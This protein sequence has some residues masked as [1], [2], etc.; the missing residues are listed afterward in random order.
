MLGELAAAW[1]AGILSL[2]EATRLLVCRLRAQRRMNGQGGM[3][4][5]AL[6]P[7][8]METYDEMQR[9]L[10]IAAYNGPR[11]VTI[12]GPDALLPEELREE[13]HIFQMGS[14]RSLQIHTRETRRRSQRGEGERPR[15][16]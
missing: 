1:A 10:V 11:S 12:A 7:R 16:T 8:A 4:A 5:V 13:H 9:G 2:E 6:D 3:M 14:R 15:R